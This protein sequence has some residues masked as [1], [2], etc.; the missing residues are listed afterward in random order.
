VCYVEGSKDACLQNPTYAGT[1]AN[2]PWKSEERSRH[3]AGSLS[4]SHRMIHCMAA[5]GGHHAI[6]NFSFKWEL[7][8]NIVST[9]IFNLHEN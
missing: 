6:C 3:P 2:R 1:E 5:L 8:L 9:K 4:A 7:F